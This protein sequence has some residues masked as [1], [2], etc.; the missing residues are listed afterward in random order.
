MS[1]LRPSDMIAFFDS[2]TVLHA[3]LAAALHG[4]AF[5]HLGHGAAL[6][7]AVRA[8][9]RLPWP[10]LVRSTCGSA[11]PKGSIR[12][13]SVTSTWR[14]WRGRWPTPIRAAPTRR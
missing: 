6:G 10:L 14:S 2:A 1:R 11:H 8:A 13:A 12:V 7:A 5:P 9:G 4:R 3:G